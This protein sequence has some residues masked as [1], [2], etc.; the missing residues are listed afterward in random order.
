MDS[1]SIAHVTLSEAELQALLNKAAFTTA[2]TGRCT[3]G[4][5]QP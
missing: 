1:Q 2:L 4:A 5:S 3:F